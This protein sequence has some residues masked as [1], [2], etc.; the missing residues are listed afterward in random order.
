MPAE[1]Q[2]AATPMGWFLRLMEELG[3]TCGAWVMSSGHDP[4]GRNASAET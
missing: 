3:I 4:Q 2:R 1:W